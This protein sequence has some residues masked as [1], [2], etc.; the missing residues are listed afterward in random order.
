M[1]PDSALPGLRNISEIFRTA[2][3]GTDGSLTIGYHGRILFHEHSGQWSAVGAESLPRVFGYS[4]AKGVSS[5]VVLWLVGSG[6][7]SY[8][9][10][11]ADVW[12]EFA[13]HGKGNLTLAEMLMHQAGLAAV[14]DWL[15]NDASQYS[16]FV[17]LENALA[18]AEPS[19]EPGTE[20]GYHAI[21]WG[22]LLN[23]IVRRATGLTIGGHAQRLFESLG[24]TEIAMRLSDV[25]KGTGVAEML[26]AVDP[27]H[28]VQ[29][30]RSESG[31][32]VGVRPRSE[33][34][35]AFGGSAL[36]AKIANPQS[37]DIEQPAVNVLASSRGLANLYGALAGTSVETALALGLSQ[38]LRYRCDTRDRVVG[39]PMHWR[40]GF[41][42]I[43]TTRGFE[44]EVIGHSGFGG[45]GAWFDTAS[46]LSCGF[47]TT[48][49]APKPFLDTRFASITSAVLDAR[50][51]LLSEFET[52]RATR[53]S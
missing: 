5:I 51:E 53:T 29:S 6:V 30:S 31:A 15:D 4:M 52:A 9:Q 14:P 10:P 41:Q 46:G 50:D 37:W 13:A 35:A 21:T 27:Y 33:T 3:A 19:Y 38:A 16:Q 42:S 20:C 49:M 23:G 2:Q 32:W 18:D 8:E 28:A 44:P 11:I 25:P 22:W 1:S 12:P 36:G 47:V 45:S 40:C 43:L 39:F 34:R 24:I 48:T 17:R 26:G 7:L